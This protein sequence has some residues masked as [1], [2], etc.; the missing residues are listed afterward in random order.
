[1]DK[2]IDLKTVHILPHPSA[3]SKSEPQQFQNKLKKLAESLLPVLGVPASCHQEDVL[4][5]D[6]PP[7][8]EKREK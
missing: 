2:D 3:E 4:D 6:G 8:S 5:I 1:M 7:S